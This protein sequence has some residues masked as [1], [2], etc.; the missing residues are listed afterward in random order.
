ML[1]FD[2]AH[3]LE[4]GCSPS[5]TNTVDHVQI[6]TPFCDIRPSRIYATVDASCKHLYKCYYNYILEK[7]LLYNLVL[8]SWQNINHASS[9]VDLKCVVGLWLIFREN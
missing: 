8:G 9:K 2:V 3:L 5:S 7:D 4:H 6:Q 1:L